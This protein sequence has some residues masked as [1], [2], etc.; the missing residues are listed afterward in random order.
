MKIVT[1]AA[2]IL[3]GGPII[4]VAGKR[5]NQRD[6]RVRSSRLVRAA[7]PHDLCAGASRLPWFMS[8]LRTKNAVI[9][10]VHLHVHED[11]NCALM[12]LALFSVVRAPR[13]VRVNI[14]ARRGGKINT[15]MVDTSRIRRLH[16]VQVPLAWAA[17]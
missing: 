16:Q 13:F 4:R 12:A 3:R 8:P 10:N 14:P 9:T 7:S 6:C 15:A 17:R 5:V 2:T 11:D 1:I